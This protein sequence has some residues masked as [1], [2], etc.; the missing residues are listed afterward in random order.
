MEF[1]AWPVFKPQRSDLIASPPSG[2]HSEEIEDELGYKSFFGNLRMA[3]QY[4]PFELRG[5]RSSG[6]NPQ[7][8]NHKTSII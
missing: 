1:R 5:S 4:S 7:A 3:E 2:W 8:E 6:N